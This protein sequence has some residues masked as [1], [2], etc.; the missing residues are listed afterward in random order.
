MLLENYF[1]FNSDSSIQLKGTRIGL[2]IVV[3]EYMAGAGADEIVLRYPTLTLEQVH[4]AILYYL[5]NQ[6]EVNAYIERVRQQHLAA[7]QQWLQDQAGGASSFVRDLR[8]R[9]AS[10]RAKRE[11]TNSEQ[12]TDET[13][14]LT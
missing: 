11:L 12:L 2:E 1:Q 10:A 5:A 14:V 6:H 7:H 8:N 3:E 9:I 13:P 4:A